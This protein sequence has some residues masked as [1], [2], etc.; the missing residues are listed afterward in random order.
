MV[1]LDRSNQNIFLQQGFNPVYDSRC[2]GERRDTRN[3]LGNGLGSNRHF[4]QSGF[5]TTR[6]I[7]DEIDFTVF[8]SV[9]DVWSA[10]THLVHGL[11]GDPVIEQNLG[12]S[13]GSVRISW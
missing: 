11:Y 12:R 1:F 13:R 2:P 7:D 5:L 6:G 3:I 9:N 4:I 10:L 8:H